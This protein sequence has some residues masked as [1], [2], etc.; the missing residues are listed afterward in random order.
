MRMSDGINKTEEEI[1]IEM[2]VS[3]H[4]EGYS[5][6]EIKKLSNTN[7]N[8]KDIENKINTWYYN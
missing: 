7:Y 5:S 1:I 8:I 4:E 2:L 6:D 3:L